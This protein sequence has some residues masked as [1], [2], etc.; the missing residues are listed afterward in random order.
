MINIILS[1]TSLL[2]SSSPL[3]DV[4]ELARS[5]QC[6]ALHPLIVSA[7]SNLSDSFDRP[8]LC[9]GIQDTHHVTNTRSIATAATQVRPKTV[10]PSCTY[11]TF[12]VYDMRRSLLVPSF[13]T[14]VICG[15]KS[16]ICDFKSVIWC[17]MK[18]EAAMIATNPNLVK[19]VS[20]V[21]NKFHCLP[22][23]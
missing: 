1:E 8:A 4:A 2:P 15:L 20:S 21:N 23:R 5:D 12:V 17:V 16:R 19:S 11:S 7:P 3:A 10:Y 18:P 14:L 22:R 13:N 6:P 9:V